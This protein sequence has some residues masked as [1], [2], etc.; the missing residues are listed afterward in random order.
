MNHAAQA[1][2]PTLAGHLAIMRPGNVFLRIFYQPMHQGTKR[3]L[4]ALAHYGIIGFTHLPGFKQL[5]H[6]LQRLAGFG[7]QDHAAY[8]PVQPVYY[9]QE[10]AVRLIVF[11]GDV[12]FYFLIATLNINKYR[13]IQNFLYLLQELE[14]RKFF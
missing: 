12:F 8:G 1:A 3:W 13:L 5:V 6:P 7:K 11:L 10:S 14:T 2:T 4:R 9:A